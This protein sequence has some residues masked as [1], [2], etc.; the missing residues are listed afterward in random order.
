MDE[1]EV[2]H[3]VVA[4]DNREG[5]EDEEEEEEERSVVVE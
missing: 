2:D 4:V 1:E 5:E 3:R